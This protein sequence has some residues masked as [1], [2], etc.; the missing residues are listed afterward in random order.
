MRQIT[1]LALILTVLVIIPAGA[2]SYDPEQK[3]YTDEA[4]TPLI[5]GTDKPKVKRCGHDTLYQYNEYTIY[6]TP[7]YKK[8]GEIVYVY[9]TD[10][11]NR[12]LCK[13]KD[14]KPFRTFD[15][16][17]LGEA[18]FFAGLS[19]DYMFIDQGTGPSYRGLSIYDL[20]D[21]KLIYYTNYTDPVL[22]HGTLTYFETISG[23]EFFDKNNKC[24][25]RGRWKTQGLSA[26]YQRQMTYDLESGEKKA[27]DEYRC[28]AG[29]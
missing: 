19:A 11:K 22:E 7:S 21:G 2:F 16:N 23:R 15:N 5:P 17:A 6:T 25:D 14:Q 24:P 28:V 9:P 26:L 8:V 29:Q 27:L 4:V 18:N 13:T 3:A 12:E 10:K 20:K 1:H